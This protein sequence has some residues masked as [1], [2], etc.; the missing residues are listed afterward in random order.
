MTATRDI[1]TNL[2]DYL[3]RSGWEPQPP[4]VGG[5]LWRRT[6]PAPG[7]YGGAGRDEAPSIAVPSGVRPGTN[8]WR[9]LINRLSAYEQRSA[10]AVAFS[11]EHY[12]VD[13]TRF[14]AANDFKI[15]GTI[16]LLAGVDLVSSAYKMLRA[17]A[18]TARQPKSHIA[19]N[20]SVLGDRLVEE[21]RLGQ[22]EEG[23]YILP[24]LIPLSEPEEPTQPEIWR[25]EPGVERVASEPPERRV[26]RTLAQALTAV[27]QL[28][29]QPAREPRKS[30]LAPLVAAGASR[31]LLV[32]VHQV[33]SDSTVAV[34]ETSFAWAGGATAPASLPAKVALPHGATTLIEKA[35]NL[36]RNSR[37]DPSTQLTGPIVEVRRVP[38]DPS[39]S[40]VVQ[41]IR[42]GRPVEVRVRLSAKQLDPTHDWMRTSRTVVV[43]G[44]VIRDPG[45]RLRIDQPRNIYPLDET[46]LH[47]DSQST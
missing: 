37:R 34:L 26:T 35:S 21:V 28:I 13:V 43:E 46:F 15:A 22:T 17:S 2:R 38:G 5:A 7:T 9:G 44:N 45:K 11:I 10:E 3:Q 27:D 4:G 47:G 32:A 20:F 8:E 25:D 40:M 1:S 18:T 31:E 12:Y 41:T 33:L 24:V 16:P 36:L 14:R 30:E 19:G 42:Q 39:G 6:S 23:S 29:V